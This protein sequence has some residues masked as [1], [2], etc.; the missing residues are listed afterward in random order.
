ME[1]LNPA[2]TRKKW[3]IPSISDRTGRILSRILWVLGPI[4]GFVMVEYLN[5]NTLASFSPLQVALNL[6]FYYL[7]AGVVY[8]IAGRRNL[9]CGIAVTLFWLIGMANHYVISFRGRTIF[10]GDLLALQT[11]AN[12]ADNYSYVPDTMQLVTLAGLAVFLLALL[13]L[14]R[15]RGRTK[16]RLRLAVP[17]AVAGVAFLALFFCTGFLARVNIE[18]SMWT[19]IGNGFV[20]NFSV[21]LRY[22]SAEKPEGYSAQALGAIQ[23]DVEDSGSAAVGGAAGA[24]RP[25]NVI[26][27]MNESFSDL[28]VVG[29]FETNQDPLPFWRSLTE[30]TVRGYAYASVFGGTTAN[31]EFEF[32][33][34]NS[35]AFTPAG[36]VPY[37]MYVKEGAASLVA[38]MKGLG[39]TSIA[40]HPYLS[41]GW[42]RPAVYGDFGFDRALFQQDFK[43]VDHYRNYITDQSNY[44]NMVRLYEEK[45]PGA[46]LFLFNVTMQNHSGYD[47]PW[48]TLP[49][50]VTLT[51]DL[52]GRYPSVDQYLSL[53][54]QSDRAFEYL[55]D[56]FSQVEEPTMILLFGDHQPQV[57]GSFYNKLLGANPGI[58]T[59][60]EKYKV[61]FLIWANYDIDERSGVETSLNYLSTLLMETA[62][63]PLTGYQQFLSA[64]HETV[65]ALNANGYLDT[66]GRWHQRVD[67]MDTAAQEAL[68]EYK[69]LQYN[70][71][72]DSRE[73]R[74]ADFFF[75]PVE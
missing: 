70:E 58:D 28:S 32:L 23:A 75:L 30:N 17:S 35:T 12:V 48:T 55:I 53:M 69:M 63:L 42:N 14:P 37:Q 29:D 10:P 41:S 24:T 34:G 15:Q 45:A 27:I 60:Q 1:L 51:G 21:C 22:S 61:P 13:L 31:S 9:S 74:L 38:Q 57:A 72:F 36:T 8:A 18:P 47:V 49:H 59:L 56:Y 7:L 20:L 62:G 44:E 33:T 19:T 68:N 2:K 26:A 64:L 71:L 40:A 46:P 6:A 43:D 25:V 65:P 67:T 16:L 5:Y 11:A 50:E 54:Y 39:Y 66:E 73:D 3:N 52:G 4:V